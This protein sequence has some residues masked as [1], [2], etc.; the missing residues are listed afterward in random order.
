MLA[1]NPTVTDE[2]RT[3]A[4][5][6]GALLTADQVATRWQ[7]PKAQVYRLTRE[8]Q[9]PTIKLGKYYRYSLGAIETFEAG[10]GTT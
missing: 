8:E 5:S 3:L 10:G 7:V 4:P 1:V 9:L 2:P 6:A